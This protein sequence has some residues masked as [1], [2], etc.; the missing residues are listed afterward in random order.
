MKHSLC[1]PLNEIATYLVLFESDPIFDAPASAEP[2]EL[3]LEEDLEPFDLSD[4]NHYDHNI[5]ALIQ[6]KLCWATRGPRI[7]LDW[8]MVTQLHVE[9][10]GRLNYVRDQRSIAE[11][12]R[13]ARKTKRRL[14]NISFKVKSKQ[15]VKRARR[16]L[17]H[18]YGVNRSM[19]HVTMYARLTAQYGAAPRGIECTPKI[20]Q[21]AELKLYSTHFQTLYN[22]N[23]N[24]VA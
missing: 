24:K 22:H 15:R 2:D 12:L 5:T 19:R 6:K 17:S 4:A 9:H 13:P 11:H 16:A 3:Q 14:A 20:S 23:T 7:R 8:A 21:L 1:V 18:L 10:W